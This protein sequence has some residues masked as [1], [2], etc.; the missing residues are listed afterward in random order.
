MADRLGAPASAV[1]LEALRLLI[2]RVELSR[3]ELR[4]T[5]SFERLGEA[6]NA[7]AVVPA[8]SDFPPFLVVAPLRLRRRGPELRMVLQGAA[9][10]VPK[11]DPVL[12]RRLIEARRCVSP[13]I[14]ILTRGLTLSAIARRAGANVGDVSRS[15]QLAFL[16]P[17]LVEA[18]LDGT[19]PIALTAERL[20]RAGE[21]PLLLGRAAGDA[22]RRRPRDRS[23]QPAIGSL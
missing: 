23:S 11:P 9:A 6:T 1:G 19:Q 5:A 21:L 18:I 22:R 10:P 17:D 15:L 14:S 13:T 3:S 16:A 4:A 7:A 8:L 12:L 2:V 20:K